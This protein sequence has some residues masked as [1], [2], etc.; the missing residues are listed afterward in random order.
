M[1]GCRKSKRFRFVFLEVFLL[2]WIDG[3]EALSLADSVA[4]LRLNECALILSEL[5]IPAALASCRKIKLTDWPLIAV[6][7][8]HDTSRDQEASS[9]AHI[10]QQSPCSLFFLSSSFSGN[11]VFG[12]LLTLYCGLALVPSYTKCWEV[13]C[14]STRIVLGPITSSPSVGG[15]SI[16]IVSKAAN[17]SLVGKSSRL[18]NFCLIVSRKNVGSTSTRLDHLTSWEGPQLPN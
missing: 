9:L 16:F 18:R 3:I 7:L 2:S 12:E 4:K 6:S 5:G 17:I 1:S 15:G 11:A 13:S 8:T 14:K 10:V